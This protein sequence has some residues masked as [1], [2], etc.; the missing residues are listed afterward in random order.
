MNPIEMHSTPDSI[1]IDAWGYDVSTM[2]LVIVFKSG[3][4]YRYAGVAADVAA[5][6][7]DTDSVGRYYAD[8]VRGKYDAEKFDG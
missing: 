2:T 5:G 7:S 6:F 1:S 8:N 3:T 4:R